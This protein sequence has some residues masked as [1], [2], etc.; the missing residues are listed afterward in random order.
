MFLFSRVK[1]VWVM[2]YYAGSADVQ[3]RQILRKNG[4]D[5]TLVWLRTKFASSTQSILFL[6]LSQFVGRTSLPSKQKQ[7]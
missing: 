3:G 7:K 5:V 1:G 2:R 6:S 4:A